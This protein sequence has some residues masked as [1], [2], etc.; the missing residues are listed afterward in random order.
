MTLMKYGVGCCFLFVDCIVYSDSLK[1][2]KCGKKKTK[3][4]QQAIHVICRRCKQN[5]LCSNTWKLVT[6]NTEADLMIRVEA[7][8]VGDLAPFSSLYKGFLQ[9]LN[10]QNKT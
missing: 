9:V 5:V 7:W 10:S 1:T 6:F 4:N 3:T 8:K 2:R